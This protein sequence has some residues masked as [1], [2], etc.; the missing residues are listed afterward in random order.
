MRLVVNCIHTRIWICYGTIYHT[1]MLAGH[2]I[3][4]DQGG[5]QNDDDYIANDE[6]DTETYIQEQMSNLENEKAA[7]LNNHSLI[8]EV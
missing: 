4:E 3:E 8:Q 1:S 5:D 6:A 2:K 7:I